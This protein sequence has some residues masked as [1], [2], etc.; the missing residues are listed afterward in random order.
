MQA[1]PVEDEEETSEPVSRLLRKKMIVKNCRFAEWIIVKVFSCGT[2][3][4]LR[5][6]SLAEVEGYSTAHRASHCSLRICAPG[7]SCHVPD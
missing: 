1:L 4:L 2:F 7:R 5:L 6:N 3:L